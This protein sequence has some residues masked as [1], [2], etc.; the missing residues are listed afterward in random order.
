METAEL[1]LASDNEVEDSID[2]HSLSLRDRADIVV[3][4]MYA[5]RKLNRAPDFLDGVDVSRL[6]RQHIHIRT[7]GQEPGDEARKGSLQDFV[8]Q[9]DELIE[10]VRVRGFIKGNAI[11]LSSQNNLPVNGAHRIAT[12][13]ALGCKIPTIR[14]DFPG[15]LWDVNWFMNAGFRQEE[16]NLILKAI[17]FLKPEKFLVSILW[18][19]VEEAWDQIQSE[20]DA[21]APV[22][23]SRTLNLARDSFEEMVC[24]IYS[25]DW[26]P[27][28]GQNILRKISLLREFPSKV[29]LVFSEVDSAQGTHC[30]RQLKEEIRTKYSGMS[31]L[32]H[33]TTVHVSESPAE[34]NHLLNIFCSENNL[35]HLSRR[36]R[37]RPE[38]VTMLANYV[39]VLRAHQLNPA[40]CCVVGGAAVDVLGLRSAD[41]VDFTLREAIRFARFNGG[42]TRLD[43][44]VDVVA[45]NYPRSFSDEAPLTDEHIIKRPAHHF[46]ARGLKFVDPSV[47]LTRRQHQRREKDLRDLKSLARYLDS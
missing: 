43:G 14:R 38:F 24:D 3:K 17:A 15:G 33:F 41:D 2:A 16:I 22:L 18:S 29:R 31:P 20:I 28:V 35:F 8:D 19:P 7:G 45:F 9:F 39:A 11:P 30:G 10:S 44:G 40:D 21:K 32:D 4:Y 6:Y 1:S 5:A 13:L 12:A 23:F 26:G 25:F 46:F 47:A 37:L 34:T 27:E 36:K 42:V